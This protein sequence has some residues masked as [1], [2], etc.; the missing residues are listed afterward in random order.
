LSELSENI[1]SPIVVFDPRRSLSNVKSFARTHAAE[2]CSGALLAIMSLQM[3]AVVW[4]KSI[5]VDEIVMI[6]SA[7]YHLV[8][9]DFQLVN[10]HPPLSKILAAIPLVF[11][12]PNEY[13][14]PRGTDRVANENAKWDR[15]GRLWSDNGDKFESISFWARVPMIVLTIALGILIFVFARR[16]FGARTAVLAVALFSLEPTI[17]GHGR[18]VQTDA[19]AALGYLLFFI[20]LH[21]YTSSTTPRRAA[22]LGAAIAVALLAK[23]SMLLVGLVL[24]PVLVVLWWRDSWRLTIPVQTALIAFSMLVVINAAY[25]FH[26]PRLNSI[27]YEWLAFNFKNHTQAVTLLINS[28]SYLVPKEFLLGI[29]FQIVHNRNGHSASLLG[30]YSQLGWWYYFP[31]ALALKT[32]IPFLLLSFTS[33][34]WAT[35]RL[36]RNH[37]FRF[38]WLLIP[39]AVY[40]VFCLFSKIDIGVRYMLPM[41]PF[42]IILSA[43]LLDQLLRMK[44]RPIG[45]VVAV[46]ALA[47]V[48][49]EAV[50]AYPNHISYMNQFAT[51]APHW[52]YLSDSNIE[53]GDDLRGLAEYLHANGERR[54]LDGTLGGFGILQFYGIECADALNQQ[55]PASD[56]PRYLAIGASFLNGSTIPE[57]PPGSGRDTMNQ[58][59]NFFAEYRRRRPE[60]IIGGSIYVFRVR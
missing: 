51:G 47:W 46:L 60:A 27:D 49:I 28:L 45:T 48:G 59:V 31:V 13:T 19:P 38:M 33:A 41:F 54:V 29:C 44:L 35:V 42:L 25:F 34:L 37:D 53:W 39:A 14:P 2:I 15:Q 20:A 22:L 8:D 52:W 12:Q 36:I 56:Q 16:L 32:T 4:R 9:A 17:L 50:R 3:L 40:M 30:M 7:Y 10:E 5:T 18:V 58:R 11:V 55:A 43:W 1:A 23:Y 24:I 21:S 57:G 6:P 26:L